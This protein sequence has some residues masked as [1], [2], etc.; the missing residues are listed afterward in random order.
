MSI[1][2]QT[3]DAL[4]PELL[5]PAGSMEALRAAVLA[6]A[7]AVYFGAGDFNARMY[8]ANF[9]GDAL[10]EAIQFCAFHG[11]KTYAAMNTLVHAR[12]LPDFLRCAEALYTCGADAL[13]VADLGAAALLHKNFPDFPLHASTQACGHNLFAARALA[14]A[15]FS[16]MVCAREASF[17]DLQTLCAASPIEIEM[18][19]HGALCVSQSGQCLFSSVIG[20]RSGNRGRCAQPCRLPYRFCGKG[21]EQY[22]LSLKD[23]C[24]AGHIT[25]LL[26][27]RVSSLKIEGRMKSPG[28]VYGVTKMYRTLLD[29]RRCADAEEMEQLARQFSRGGLTDGYFVGKTDHT[30]LGIRSQAD[31]DRTAE[32]EKSALA[33]L[34]EQEARG[35]KKHLINLCFTAQKDCPICL[36]LRCEEIEVCVTGP[37][38][39][40]AENTALDVAAV[41]RQLSRLGNTPY[42]AAEITCEIQPALSVPLSALNDLRRRGI[43]TLCRA[44]EQARCPHRETRAYRLPEHLTVQREKAEERQITRQACF[45]HTEQIVPQAK[46]Y[47]ERIWLP[48]QTAVENLPRALAA[49]VQGVIL[50]PVILDGRTAQVKKMLEQVRAAGMTHALCGVPGQMQLARECGLIPCGSYRCNIYSSESAAVWHAWGGEELCISPELTVPRAGGIRVPGRKGA[51]VY[52]RLPLMQLRRCVIRQTDTPCGSAQEPTGYDACRRENLFLTDRTG[53]AFPLVPGFDHQN[54]LL[55][56]VPLYMGDRPQELRAMQCDYHMFLFSVETPSQI[57]RVMHDYTVGAPASGAHRRIPRKQELPKAQTV[58]KRGHT[59]N[60]T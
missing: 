53:A 34:R 38:P 31:K 3:A 21:R 54:M 45:F 12:E 29:E 32:A 47:F 48:L 55:N 37:L 56:S 50:P 20:G 59:K 10:R 16:R 49:G 41:R 58:R 27:L 13:I 11:V 52:G 25:E 2:T 6:G 60:R 39:D 5:A 40:A 24:L 9:D 8:A 17:S 22:L 57:Q 18:F 35:G 42:E 4:L 30:M 44:M 23:Y 43:Q 28:Y 51:V 33:A 19:I 36:V 14:E 7:D 26:S 15:G 46:T 1:Q